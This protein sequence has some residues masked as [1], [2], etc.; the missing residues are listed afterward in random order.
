MIKRLLLVTLV[1][2]L[3]AIAVN[4]WRQ[5]SQ[6]LHV[7]ATTPIALD[8][9]LA[10][11]HLAGA[12]RF[13][14]IA[15]AEVADQSADQFL[16][17]HDYLQRTYPHVHAAMTREIVG[18]Y[19]LLYRWQGSDAAARPVMLMAH[20]D[21]VPIAAGTTASWQVAPFEGVIRDGFV[22]GRGAWDN[23]GN[24]LSMLEALER[25]AATG[26]KPRQTIYLAAGADEEVGG[27]RGALAIAGLLQSRGVKLDY[28]LDEGLII[29]DGMMNGLQQ[30]AALIGIAE[31]GYATIYLSMRGAPGHSSMPPA[32]S[33]IGSMS[34]ALVRLEQHPLPL[35]IN[36]A[37]RAML[38]TLAPEMTL[39]NRLLLSNL[40]LTGP[41]VARQ[42]QKNP[43]T[44][45]MLRTTAALT[46]FN[47]GN[48]D[49]IL[50][51]T[52][53]AAVNFRLLP[54]DSEAGMLAHV[55]QV[56]ANEAITVRLGAGNSP[57]SSVADTQSASYRTINRTV[58]EIFPEA[59]VAPGLMIGA[60]DSRYFASIADNVYRFSPVRARP[61]DLARFHGTNERISVRN[62]AE[63]IQ[64]YYRLLHTA[65]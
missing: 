34:A 17:L 15:S 40:W 47:A 26:F 56:V 20:Q 52:A 29:T 57:P 58:R 27:K 32:T 6:Q 42:L 60:T 51:G 36:G 64:F 38:T 18:K 11:Q 22:W 41:L 46:I 10:A 7:A 45:A 33:L 28:V 4:T 14:T 39:T 49:N 30:P 63:M 21:V 43:S 53:D 16:Q 35:K 1:C 44:N 9:N 19:S 62:F 59:L 3:L 5:G 2:L 50:P 37:A 54:G 31:K 55:R 23:K 48:K 61:D 13:Q 25:L 12:L 8:A 65:G 24:L